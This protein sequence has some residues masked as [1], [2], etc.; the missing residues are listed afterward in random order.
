VDPTIRAGWRTFFSPL[1]AYL[2]FRDVH[3]DPRAGPRWSPHA[4]AVVYVV[5][6]LSFLAPGWWWLLAWLSFVPL[7]PVQSAINR[8]HTRAGLAV[9]SR[10]TGRD[11]AVMAGGAILIALLMLLMALDRAM[12]EELIMGAPTS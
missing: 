6:L 1:T 10:I 3:N 11:A 7:L 9:D 5:M 12:L 2:L 4:L 8:M